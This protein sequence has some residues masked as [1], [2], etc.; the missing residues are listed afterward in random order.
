MRRVAGQAAWACGVVLHR[1]AQVTLAV[2]VAL[3]VLAVG[4]AWRLSQGPVDLSWFTARLETTANANHGPVR[5]SIGG[6]AL[7][8][9][10]FSL[11]VD[12]PLDLQLTDVTLSAAAGKEHI[13]VPRAEVS[14]S[15]VALLMG[16]LQPRAVELDNPSLTLRRSKDGAIRLD[17]GKAAG[18]QEV[19]A[20]TADGSLP[21]LLDVLAQPPT[22][23]ATMT[24][25]WLGQIRRVRIHDASVT[26]V[27]D[28]LSVTWHAPHA[29]VDLDR[30]AE[31]GVDGTFKLKLAVGAANARLSGTLTLSPG[32][33]ETELS[34]QLTPVS[35]AA[36]AAQIPKLASIAAFNA[37]VGVAAALR[38]GPGF[39][40]KQLRA[41]LSASS[42]TLR[43]SGNN[44]PVL[45]A[46][47]ALSGTWTDMAIDTA[48]V[49]L[50]GRNGGPTTTLTS[51]G[52]LHWVGQ[53]FEASLSLGLD[54]VDFAD[55]P[56]LWPKGLGGGARAWITQN[57]TAG[58]A[59]RGQFR[60]GLSGDRN[61]LSAV[62]VTSASG[63][64]QGS[65]LTV[66]WLR[67]VPP[68]EQGRAELR[69]INPDTME[70]AVASARQNLP[71]ARATLT[72]RNGSVRITGLTQ[73]EQVSA[74][75]T[76]V[77]GT[78]GSVV[79]LLNQPRLHLLHDHPMGLQDPQGNVT[80]SVSVTLPLDLA[81][82][83]DAVAV[84]T[85]AHVTGAHLGDAIAG[86]EL[87]GATLDVTADNAGL[88]MK[89]Q[90]QLAGIA[91]TLDVAMDFRAGPPS[92]VL[93]RIV[94]SARPTAAQ[95][96]AAG[97]DATA[98]ASGP[99]QLRAVLTERRDGAGRAQ[100]QGD[101]SGA[102]LSVAPL[103][104]HKPANAEA[105][106]SAELRLQNDRLTGING[107][108]LDGAGVSLRASAQCRD[109]SVTLLRVDRL[110]LG[111][112]DMAGTVRLPATSKKAPIVIDLS[113]SQIDLSARLAQQTPQRPKPPVKSRPWPPWTVNARFGRAL[114]ANGYRIA[115]LT[116]QASD[117]GV[118]L[119]RLS[120]TGR[121]GD[122]APFSL[123]IASDHG[124]RRLTASATDTGELLRALN[125][126]SNME[127]GK[128]SV[129]GTYDD[130]HSGHTLTGSA[131]LSQFRIHGA[132]ALGRLLQAMTLYGLV[133]VW[134]GPGLAFA[135]LVAPFRLTGG[136]LQLT[137]ARA[138]SPSLGLTAKGW[139]D[140]D[141]AQAD[142]QGT[143]VPAYFFNALLGHVPLVG[144]LFSPERGGGVFAAS[145]TLRGKLAAPT[146][147][148]NPLAALTPGF[149]RG[150]FH[151][152]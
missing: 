85:T 147:R 118:V 33:T 32:A 13:V 121:A 95:L 15:L 133:D 45:G 116:V 17:L 10:G 115:P 34:A 122:K 129:T 152:F 79:A 23:D 80:A 69:V 57:I 47:L 60:I 107:I 14:L 151:T 100:L 98:V 73:K 9:E 19:G 82:E 146:V 43:M 24:H 86:H 55:L 114:M 36:L 71:R 125:V 105:R 138:F 123:Q 25:S 66:H 44:V 111:R 28:A 102:T 56:V 62:T 119:S 12:R 74:I 108:R 150:V 144:R 41:T 61:D 37:P 130:A 76:D 141:A 96:A 128:L 87:S 29:D 3:A 89:G 54:R 52:A 11:G 101:L 42:G 22:T 46:T 67:P 20:S 1:L 6:T 94:A 90:G 83:M 113:G 65:G 120:V 145:Y 2:G 40:L 48:R 104:W 64:L 39:Q 49:V 93:Q 30:R 109:G 103:A 99:M 143:I 140:F 135:T 5:V 139:I 149:L 148:V 81:V 97:L 18:T 38:L 50:R 142:L 136:T 126:T 26:M 124:V 72:L 106:A 70:I 31:G 91:T 8:W 75:K 21:A 51:G 78:L 88:T 35:P 68:L 77:V 27:D 127:G 7:A 16:R 117:D 84:R 137:D 53:R 92:Q 112:S 134:R 110:A 63:T 58:T 131:Q 132:P 4:A 59:S